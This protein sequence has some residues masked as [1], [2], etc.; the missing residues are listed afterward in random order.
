MQRSSYA[1]V[2]T[3]L[4]ATALSCT[5]SFARQ[6]EQAPGQTIQKTAP[7]PAIPPTA[8]QF[9]RFAA[10]SLKISHVVDDYRAKVDAAPTDY[11]K[12]IVV[13]EADAK[14][15]EIVRADGMTV[16]EFNGI[17]RAVQENP[18]LKQ[19]IKEMGANSR[20]SH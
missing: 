11:A 17:A 9:E 12:R 15:V 1:F 10:T 8:Q 2:F 4:L 5:P 6:A 7:P 3:A 18:E 19:R 13:K 16:E 14:M 20:A